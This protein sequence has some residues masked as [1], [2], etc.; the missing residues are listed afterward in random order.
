MSR[1]I[2]EKMIKR[3]KITQINN[4]NSEKLLLNIVNNLSSLDFSKQ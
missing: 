1:L 4:I 2:Q 3:I